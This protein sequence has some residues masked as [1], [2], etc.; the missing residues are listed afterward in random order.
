MLGVLAGL[1]VGGVG[2]VS[3]LTES[4]GRFIGGNSYGGIL[5]RAR[6]PKRCGRGLSREEERDRGKAGRKRGR[7]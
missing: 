2:K 4:R 6:G 7:E 5:R 1:A 3:L